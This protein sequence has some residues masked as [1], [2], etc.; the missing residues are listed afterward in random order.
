MYL[1]DHIFDT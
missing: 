1:A